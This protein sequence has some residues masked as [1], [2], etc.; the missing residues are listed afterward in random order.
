MIIKACYIF[1]LLWAV[2]NVVVTFTCTGTVSP[3][4]WPPVTQCTGEAP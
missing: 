3:F 4:Y 1:C 2:Y